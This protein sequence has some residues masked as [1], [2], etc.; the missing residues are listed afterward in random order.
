MRV[1]Y[2][3][4]MITITRV[5][6]VVVSSY[7]VNGSLIPY[8]TWWGI[9]VWVLIFVAVAVMCLVIYKY[10]E[11]IEKYFKSL[12]SKRKEKKNKIENSEQ[13]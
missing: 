4:V 7:S 10:G 9:L 13:K 12:F 3:L 1:P 6:N 11:K 2:Y 8:N 5:I